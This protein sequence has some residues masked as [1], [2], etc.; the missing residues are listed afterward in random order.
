MSD[1]NGI[2]IVADPAC[3]PGIAYIFTEGS[4]PANCPESIRAAVAD[5]RVGVIHY[6]LDAPPSEKYILDVAEALKRV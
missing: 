1:L 2:K 5:G 3:P 6:T 4:L